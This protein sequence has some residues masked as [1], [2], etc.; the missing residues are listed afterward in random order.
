[1]DSFLLRADPSNTV[2]VSRYVRALTSA[3]ESKCPRCEGPRERMQDNWHYCLAC[4]LAWKF[5]TVAGRLTLRVVPQ[6]TQG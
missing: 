3:S 1:M 4:D 6:I 2:E 5:E